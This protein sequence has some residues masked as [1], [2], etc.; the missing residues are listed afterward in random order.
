MNSDHLALY[1][2]EVYSVDRFRGND[3]HRMSEVRCRSNTHSAGA[4]VLF[5]DLQKGRRVSKWR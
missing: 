3:T 2:T 5:C 1:V 4:Q